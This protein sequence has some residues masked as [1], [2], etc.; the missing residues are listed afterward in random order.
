M[1]RWTILREGPEWAINEIVFLPGALKWEDDRKYPLCGPSSN[2]L[3]G[4]VDDVRREDDVVSAD[5]HIKDSLNEEM[6]NQLPPDWGWTIEVHRVAQTDKN[7]ATAALLCVYLG[8]GVP[9]GGPSQ[10]KQGS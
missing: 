5:L 7:V 10:E 6:F 1:A 8:C 9:W 3:I 2:Q 4:Y